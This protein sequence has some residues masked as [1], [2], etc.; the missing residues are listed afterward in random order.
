MVLEQARRHTRVLRRDG[1]GM[2][3][4]MKG[5]RADIV[6]VSNGRGHHI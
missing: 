6:E 5:A 4:R 1:V 2:S 3:E